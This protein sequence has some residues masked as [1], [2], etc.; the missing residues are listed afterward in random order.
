MLS[1]FLIIFAHISSGASSDKCKNRRVDFT[2]GGVDYFF[3]GY[4]T[5]VTE[6]GEVDWLRAREICHSYCSDLMSVD[7][8]AE[9]ETVENFMEDKI[10]DFLWTSGHVCEDEQCSGKS[11]RPININGWMWLDKMTKIPPT[12]KKPPGW[13][14]NP[15]SHTGYHKLPQPDNA[16]FK[17]YGNEES[18]LA[19]LY[20]VYADGT[21]FHDVACYHPKNFFCEG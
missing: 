17:L 8:Q 7:T 9:F 16:E 2:I 13:S 1:I 19:M 20:N 12:N 14:F 10:V 3:N 6:N 5:D 21:K 18:C 15:W 11:S 4:L